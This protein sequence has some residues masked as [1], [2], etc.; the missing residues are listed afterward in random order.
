MI[1]L[2]TRLG[3]EIYKFSIVRTRGS[4][5][6]P[7]G[8]NLIPAWTTGSAAQLLRAEE[9]VCEEGGQQ[10]LGLAHQLGS[11]GGLV[12]WPQVRNGVR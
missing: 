3:S 6:A 4:G 5:A 1:M 8:S 10:T 2:L 7:I 11:L 12:S 9:K